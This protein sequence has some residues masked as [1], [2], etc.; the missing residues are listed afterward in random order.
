[1]RSTLQRGWMTACPHPRARSADAQRLIE[2]SS[3]STRTS[4]KSCRY[5]ATL[6]EASACCR[7]LSV[8]GRSNFRPIDPGT[9]LRTVCDRGSSA[10]LYRLAYTTR[11]KILERGRLDFLSFDRDSAGGRGKP[12]TLPHGPAQ[13]ARVLKRHAPHFPQRVRSPMTFMACVR[14]RRWNSS[15]P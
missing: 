8:R 6:R 2:V 3:P 9:C 14:R 15:T 4:V 12:N 7:M 13:V 11:P 5:P 10:L 1:M